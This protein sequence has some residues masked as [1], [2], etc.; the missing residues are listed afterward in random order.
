MSWV[1]TESRSPGDLGLGGTSVQEDVRVNIDINP[2]DIQSF[3]EFIRGEFKCK[4]S[5]KD[6]FGVE[7]KDPDNVQI[8]IKVGDESDDKLFCNECNKSFDQRA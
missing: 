4:L 2:E 8:Q 6:I 5:S 7:F 1:A 3:T